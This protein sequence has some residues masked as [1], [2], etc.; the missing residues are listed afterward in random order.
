MLPFP[1][2]PGQERDEIYRDRFGRLV[3]G[4]AHSLL[5]E[6]LVRCRPCMCQAFSGERRVAWRTGWGRRTGPFVPTNE[7]LEIAIE[8]DKLLNGA[9]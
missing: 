6:A 4:M 2:C 3:L 5:G 9:E 1:L 8:T 7:E